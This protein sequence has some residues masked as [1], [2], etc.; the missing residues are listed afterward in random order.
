MKHLRRKN[1]FRT[2]QAVVVLLCISL[3]VA[4]RG[5]VAEDLAEGMPLQEVIEKALVGGAGLDDL[6]TE[7]IAAEVEDADIICGCIGAGIEGNKVI[8][9]ALNHNMDH[10]DVGKWALGCG[11]NITDVQ[12]GYSMAGETMTFQ[13][14]EA[15]IRNAEEYIYNPPS[16]SQ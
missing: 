7:L 3:A 12:I 14:E 9:T 6:F 13:G 8:A 5:G 11:A 16:P 10:S 2:L 15:F 4:A 1:Y